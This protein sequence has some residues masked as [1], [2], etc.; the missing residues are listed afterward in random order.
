MPATQNLNE[1]T[2]N[3]VT[4]PGGRVVDASTLGSGGSATGG[5]AGSY[6]DPFGVGSAAYNLAGNTANSNLA[7]SGSMIQMSNIINAQNE[8]QQQML[9][10]AR[11]GPQGVETQNYLLENANREAQGLLDPSTEQML[12]QG[13]AAQGNASGMGV[14]SANLASAYRRALGLDINATEQQGQTNYLGLL[15]ANPSAP[16]Y[17]MSGQLVSPAL[18][19]KTAADQ[20]NAQ[21]GGGSGG[22]SSGGSGPRIIGGANPVGNTPAQNNTVGAGSGNYSTAAPTAKTP[23]GWSPDTYS[24]YTPGGSSVFGN[25]DTGNGNSVDP[26]D[27]SGGLANPF[28]SMPDYSNPGY[29]P[30]AAGLGQG[31]TTGNAYDSTNANYG[32]TYYT[33][34]NWA[35]TDLG[36][37]Y[38][39]NIGAN[40]GGYT[41]SGMT[42]TSGWG[43]TTTTPSDEDW[44][45]YYYGDG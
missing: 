3:L 4:L 30:I 22:T 25:I 38:D 29:D 11:L 2:S 43:A 39:T 6:A 17:D 5:T 34:Y 28:G 33:P 18:Y 20:A 13:I 32:N 45:S 9:N 14:D 21:G 41:G 40:Y 35:G 31:L 8:A 23:T 26:F 10:N 7:G 24:N 44:A 16:L 37:N 15:A 1:A 42:D 36:Y 12:Q 19:E 27:P